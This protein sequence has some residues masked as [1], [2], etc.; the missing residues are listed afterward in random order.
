MNGRNIGLQA[1][2]PVQI[3]LRGLP[4]SGLRT[5]W[6]DRLQVYVPTA[7]ILLSNGSTRGT[8]QNDRKTPP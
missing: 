8:T 3:F 4:W 6:P 5:H 1:V 2:L 7:R